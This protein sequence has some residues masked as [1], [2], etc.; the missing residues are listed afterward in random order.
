MGSQEG[1]ANEVMS[2]RGYLR[3]WE[4]RR[5]PETRKMKFSILV[6]LW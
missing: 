4:I 3:P 6:C 2:R 5:S 1:I